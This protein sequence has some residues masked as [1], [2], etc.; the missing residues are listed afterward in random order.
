MSLA[1]LFLLIRFAT[2]S[3]LVDGLDLTVAGFLGYPANGL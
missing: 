2:V 1:K 3:Q